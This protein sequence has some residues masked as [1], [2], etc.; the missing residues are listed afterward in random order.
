M[1]AS[2]VLLLAVV[3]LA[4]LI[5]VSEGLDRKENEVKEVKEISQEEKEVDAPKND[6]H[7]W[8]H[9]HRRRRYCS[10]VNCQTSN[11][12]HWGSC[13][14]HST[15]S[16]SRNII[17]NAACGG[18]PCGALRQTKRCNPVVHGGWA[19]WSGWHRCNKNCGG[20]IQYR[21]RTC[22][23]PR[24]ANGG[25]YCHGS[26][27]QSRTCNTRPCRVNGGWSKWCSWH[28]CSKT[29]GYGVRSR[30][31]TCTSPRPANGGRSCRG[32]SKQ[33]ARCK[34]RN[35]P[36]H[37]G[38][39][40]WSG[41]RK[42]SKTCGGGIQYRYRTCTRP[43]PAY[44][45]RYCHG[46]SNESRK[47][48][49]RP[50]PAHGGWSSWGAWHAC[51]K[52]CGKGVTYRT[53]TC[54]N[55]YYHYHHK[56]PGPD[57]ET[58]DCFEK[59]CPVNGGWSAWEDQHPCSRTCG[60]GHKHR[61][62]TCTNPKPAYG[63]L[64]CPGSSSQSVDCH[65]RDCPINYEHKGCFTDRSQR[66]MGEL[67]LRKGAQD[68]I[69]A[70]ALAVRNSNAAYECFGLQNDGECWTSRDAAESYNK[71]GYSQNCKNGLGGG[72]ANDVYCFN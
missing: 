32:P 39:A 70:C 72:W 51:S 26:S 38:W 66:T 42:C 1:R 16:R 43:R 2:T 60:H 13:H 17:K 19:R 36:R 71:Y 47:C 8:G 34:V 41:W 54:H 4:V 40:R 35:C 62:R 21:Y 46:S 7:W 30:Y 68:P 10:R 29:C 53:R 48:N 37:G 18:S 14:Y 5:E 15:Q 44:G 45:G 9:K 12:S 11:W 65:V 55:G 23:S 22:T 63:G 50:C 57:K 20:G 31:R 59:H 27:K 64:D 6:P 67:I 61:T 25:R 33:T 24:P 3:L 28:A 58:K 69:K 52:T 56:C 49:T